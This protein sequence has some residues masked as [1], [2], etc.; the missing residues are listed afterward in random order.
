MSAL[1]GYVRDYVNAWASAWDRFWFT[2]TDPFTLAVI[3]ILTGA[4]LFYTYLVWTFDFES[5]FGEHPWISHEAIATLGDREF[6]WSHFNWIDSPGL[7]RVIHGVA[8]I[9]FGM[10]TVGLWSR[11]TA[12]LSFLFAVSYANRL[13]PAALFGL[14]QINT[15]LA[16]Y[17]MIGPSGAALSLDRLIQKRKMRSA[18]WI[19][20]ETVRPST[21]ANLAI[22]LMQVHLCIIYM[23]SGLGKLLGFRWWEGTALWGAVANLE[24]QSIDATWLAHWPLLVNFMTHLTVAWEVFYIAL[25]WPRLTRPIMLLLAIPL[26]LGIAVFLG[27]I[28][29][30]SVMLIANLAFVSP[31]FLRILL[32]ANDPNGAAGGA[33]Q[34]LDAAAG[35]N[36]ASKSQKKR[37]KRLTQ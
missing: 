18:S 28:T 26:H 11:A 34:S 31:H 24:Y 30:G 19:S 37:P 33:G 1:T 14:D 15:M 5:F 22:R 17:V 10:L 13:S 7:L 6:A 32:R 16:M 27:M 35:E 29:F 3:R 9:V 4:M 21:T 20:N 2:P 8:L 12:I 23:F 36:A 25:I